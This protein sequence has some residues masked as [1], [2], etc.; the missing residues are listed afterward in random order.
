MLRVLARTG[1]GSLQS[2]MLHSLMVAGLV[3]CESPHRPVQPLL[4]GLVEWGRSY[5]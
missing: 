2:L 3:S 5:E 4:V 1:P